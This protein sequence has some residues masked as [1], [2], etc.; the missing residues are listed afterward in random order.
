MNA[1]PRF[2]VVMLLAG[3]FLAAT[4][5]DIRAEVVRIEI[6]SRQP[7]ND[8][9]AVGTIGE[10][11]ILRGKI[12]GELDPA[13]PHNR[14]IQDLELAP[15]NER[16]K[17]E[18]V[19]TFALA[20]P[21]D[22]TRAARV[23]LYQVVNRGN[24][25]VTIG[26]E[27]Y[28]SLVSG[29][30][31][32]VVPTP[33]NQTI[34]V[35]V[36]KARDGGI[37]TGQ[38]MARF[39][40]VPDGASTA[41]VRLASLGTPQPYLPADL[42]EPGAVMTMFTSETR[43]GAQQGRQTIARSDWAF[44]NCDKTPFPGTPDPARVCLR[45]GFRSDRAYQLVYTAKDPL[46]LGVGLAATRDIVSFFRYAD[47]D[48][49]GTP[50][51]VA[52]A[53]ERTVSIGDSQSGNFIRTFIHLGFNHDESNR[54]VWDGAFPRIAAR[55]TPMNLR[56]ALPGGAAGLYEPG[57]DGVVWWG[58]YADRTR[59][60]K[61]AS[62]LDRCTVSKT[63]PKIIEAFGSAEFWGLRMSPD[64]IGTDAKSD[65]PLPDNVRRYYY[66]GTTH[67]G[68]RG[69]FRVEPGGPVAFGGAQ[70]EL[71]E[72]PNPEADT[73]RAL[74]RALVEWVTRG[75]PPPPS[76]YPTLANG[77]L[78]AP[79]RAATGLT[80]IPGLTF[81]DQ[82][83]NPL[84]DYDFGPSFKAAD[85][86]GTMTVVPPRVRRVLPTYV[87]RVNRDGNETAGVASV[88]Y[89]APL[90]TYLGWN[91]IRSGFLTGQGCGFAGGYIPFA[92][93]KAER[94]AK[95]DPRLSLEERYGTQEGYSCVVRRAAE[96][97]VTDRFLLPEDAQRIITE[98]TASKVLPSATE[99]P[100]EDVAIGSALCAAGS[101]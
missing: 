67:G 90:G 26:P 16:G 82:I 45:G 101:Q 58:R 55:Q 32:D 13:D 73:T 70:C 95:K 10:F 72:N 59:G 38:V 8:G 84:L 48:R 11:E 43:S 18:Y 66:P 97:A 31:G 75:T 1:Y 12:Y 14:I 74:T 23:L 47:R 39:I 71:P 81:N 33:N 62:L 9:R 53:I 4:P 91:V 89:Q 6:L 57:S 30:Q 100:S 56:F 17:V 52:G 87:P 2:K 5:L 80:E 40:D 42:A 99:S 34:V 19:A 64:F 54:I 21:V 37:I 88:L 15:R 85:V 22:M 49:S 63:C 36:A 50:N 65:I 44:A 86:S 3:A 93:T 94:L 69:G 51:P 41:P 27:G 25:Q 78:V 92:R 60:L 61:T 28:I 83:V 29:W 68:G 35:P 79:A 98:A 20:K 76:R 46:V 24:G 7:A 96:Q 77:D